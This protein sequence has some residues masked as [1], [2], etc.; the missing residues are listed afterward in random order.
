MHTVIGLFHENDFRS[1]H[2]LKDLQNVLG[3][4]TRFVISWDRF[5][6][7]RRYPAIDTT[8]LHAVGK[9][10]L[11]DF[12]ARE[13]ALPRAE[14][15]ALCTDYKP[16]LKILLA[17]HVRRV[18][19]VEYAMMTDNDIYLFEDI[20]EVRQLAQ[21]RIPFFIP[22]ELVSDRLGTMVRAV[23]D[24]GR[25]ILYRAPQRGK[26]YNVG[27]CGLDLRMLDV[28]DASTAR[29]VVDAFV[30]E[31]D[32]CKEQAFLVMLAFS[33]PP[34]QAGAAMARVHSF[35]GEKYFFTAYDHPDYMALSRIYHCILSSN[36]APVNM[37]YAH[38]YAW[39]PGLRFDT[40]VNHCRGRL[41][42]R[43]LQIGGADTLLGQRLV[44]NSFNPYVYH[45]CFDHF[46]LSEG[47]V[48]GA[49]VDASPSARTAWQNL[50]NVTRR[51]YLYD[52]SRERVPTILTPSGVRFELVCVR[53]AA[54]PEEVADQLAGLI[55]LLTPDGL[56]AF[57]DL[58][59]AG[60]DLQSWGR[61]AASVAENIR[62]ETI[63]PDD[64]G[65]LMLTLTRE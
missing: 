30:A 12:A 9:D 29:G 33:D 53:G 55:G 22:E 6:E 50:R 40:L 61:L 36:K 41:M 56:L 4:D 52:A 5:D 34:E 65:R 62:L 46:G 8:N 17:L 25:A 45:Y 58:D 42:A 27:F 31:P 16:F 21:E 14:L 47:E 26:G 37:L 23:H 44:L 35:D 28:L 18:M 54:T 10:E 63:G 19:G 32:W 1:M 15:A 7:E 60:F 24:L 38:R 43:T 49:R 2:L 59:A 48:V 13:L 64:D 20:P 3:A 39:I 51:F 11:L 57:G